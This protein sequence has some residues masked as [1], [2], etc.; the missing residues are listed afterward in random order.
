[1]KVLLTVF[2]QLTRTLMNWLL[3]SLHNTNLISKPISG[4]YEVL[5]VGCPY[6]S[7]TIHAQNLSNSTVKCVES[8]WRKRWTG[9]FY[10]QFFKLESQGDLRFLFG[11]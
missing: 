11:Y 6:P 4:G 8:I 1:M 10:Y 3:Q 7:G 5:R 2:Q 9:S